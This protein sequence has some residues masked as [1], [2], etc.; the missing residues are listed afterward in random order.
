[1]IPVLEIVNLKAQPAVALSGR[2]QAE[3][4][5]VGSAVEI[6]RRLVQFMADVKAG[7]PEVSAPVYSH[8]LYDILPD[9]FQV[10]RQL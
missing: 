1:M 10:V 8:L 6:R 4:G 3:P 2:F 9:Q 5:V 7:E